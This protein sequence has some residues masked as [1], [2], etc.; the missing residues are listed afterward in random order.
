MTLTDLMTAPAAAIDEL[1]ASSPTIP[2]RSPVTVIAGLRAWMTDSSVDPWGDTG[3]H[4]VICAD[5]AAPA[6][7]TRYAR[8]S[9]A[10]E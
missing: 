8:P 9:R 1:I 3:A 4:R 5:R 6:A 7:A 10:G 2:T